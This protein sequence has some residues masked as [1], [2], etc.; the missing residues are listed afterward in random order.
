MTDPK[1]NESVDRIYEQWKPVFNQDDYKLAGANYHPTNFDDFVLK[2]MIKRLLASRR[3]VLALA[4]SDLKLWIDESSSNEKPNFSPRVANTFMKKLRGTLVKTWIEPQKVGLV[5]VKALCGFY[6]ILEPY[7]AELNAD[8]EGDARV[9][10]QFI[11][12]NRHKIQS[13]AELANLEKAGEVRAKNIKLG[14][15]PNPQEDC[16]SEFCDPIDI[17]RRRAEFEKLLK[18]K[19][20]PKAKSHIKKET[21]LSSDIEKIERAGDILKVCR[22]SGFWRFIGKEDVEYDKYQIEYDRRNNLKKSS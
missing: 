15:D 21:G 6:E 16:P 18:A 22:S 19:I 1:F 10:E 2:E 20:K 7:K 13:K 12:A 17:E 14:I 8:V 9:L 4:T 3:S 5:G 11:K